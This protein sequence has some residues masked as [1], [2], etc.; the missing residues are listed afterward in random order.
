MLVCLTKILDGKHVCM[1]NQSPQWE[2]CL[3]VLPKPL[4]GKMFVCF[5][6]TLYG[7]DVFMV[8]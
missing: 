4:I 6:Q 8:Y 3:F 7:S 5:T 1:L 2:R